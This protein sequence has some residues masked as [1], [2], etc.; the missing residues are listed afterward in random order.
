MLSAADKPES[1]VIFLFGAG[2]SV[3]AGIPDTYTFVVDFEEYI[4]QNHP[5]LSEL[6]SEILSIREK[7]NEKTCSKQRCQV[8]VEQ[9]LETLR[10]LID[11]ENDSL[12]VFYKEKKFWIAAD[13]KSFVALKTILEN[14]I[15]EKVIIEEESKLG[16]LREL[17]NFDKPIEIF[18]TNYDTCIEQ[19]SHIHYKKYTDGFDVYWNPDNFKRDFDVKHYKMH[20]SAIWYES[21]KTKECVKIPVHAFLEDKPVE[22]K[23]IYGEDVKPLLIYPAQKAE[24]IEPLTDLQLKFKERLF[25]KKTKFLVFVGYSFRDDYIIHMIWDAARAN[26]NLHAILIS[27]NAQQIFEDKLKYI[28]KPMNDVSRIS[29]RVLCLPYPFF[30]VINKLRNHY[31]SKLAEILRVFQSS[32]EVERSGFGEPNWK[33]LVKLC[34]DAEFLTKCEHVLQKTNT[35]WQDLRFGPP[36]E[37]LLYGFKALLHSVICGDGYEDIWLKRVNGIL[38]WFNVENLYIADRRKN[39]VF[40]GISQNG[41]QLEIAKFLTEW[42]APL[43]REEKGKNELLG[44]KFERS[45]AR[46]KPSLDRLKRFHECLYELSKG[47]NWYSY[48]ES[49]TDSSDVKSFIRK[50]ETAKRCGHYIS[51]EPDNIILGV[52]KG[53]L[54]TFLG[55]DSFQFTLTQKNSNSEF[56]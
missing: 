17:L 30:T 9:L 38:G 18:S 55:A 23:L 47:I 1:E 40:M 16:Y 2:A 48:K 11:R 33:Y 3:D 15:R 6:L 25:R 20:G 43:I 50:L 41:N 34:I 44:P 35:D 31:I 26:E 37:L 51:P 13:Q 53:R 10:R 14:F 12:L 49:E 8:D 36:S 19:L 46:I 7:F 27:P 45:F 29:E 54:R 24:Y 5:E 21:I 28:N 52:E 32:L 22:L 42:I 4:K 39:L 56:E